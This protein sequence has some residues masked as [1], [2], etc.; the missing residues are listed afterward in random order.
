MVSNWDVVQ[1]V[2]RIVWRLSWFTCQA[3]EKFHLKAKKGS[4]SPTSR[5]KEKDRKKVIETYQ[6]HEKYALIAM[7][8]Q[9]FCELCRIK[10]QSEPSQR[11]VYQRTYGQ[12]QS[13]GEMKNYLGDWIKSK[14]WTESQ[15]WLKEILALQTTDVYHTKEMI[16]SS[17]E[18]TRVVRRCC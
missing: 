16:L 3:L 10:D 12:I 18:R 15:N 13:L 4:S 5:V 11:R 7:I 9:G 6:A 14:I 2:K 1:D 8:A 17:R